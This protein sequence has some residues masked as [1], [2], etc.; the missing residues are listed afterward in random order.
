MGAGDKRDSF[1]RGAL[2][3]SV[4][5]LLTRVL[6]AVYRIPLYRLIG[7]EGMGLVQM[8]YPIY[9]TLLA[10]S[11]IGIPIAIS[12]M[13]AENL[14][15][16]NRSGAYRVFYL[17]L[18][19]LAA[20][21]FLFSLLLFFGAQHFA[22]TV[23][24]DPRSALALAAIAPA[25]FLVTVTSAFRGFFQGHLRMAPT[26]VSQVLEQLVRVGT[27]F[28]LAY[29]LMPRGLE[30]AAAGATF[31]A[32][33]GALVALGYLT[34]LFIIGRGAENPTRR[35]PWRVPEGNLQTVK[36]IVGLAV[37]ISLAG[38]VLPLILLVDM[39][40]VPRQLQAA[41]VGM[42][43]ATALYGQLSGG[44]M[45]LVNLPTVFTVA[46]ATS[47]V[48]AI[49]GASALGQ[50]EQIRSKV[51]TAL[52]LTTVI[53]LP[54]AAGLYILAREICAFLYAAPEVGV[55]LKSLAFLVLFLGFQ[56]TSAAVLQALG[57]T[58]IP[59]R[60]LVLGAILKLALTW[61]LTPVIG[62]QGAGLASVAGFLLAALMD[63][64]VIRRI[65]AVSLPVLGVLV[66]PLAATL[67][68]GL[69]VKASYSELL[70]VTGSNGLSVLG[71]VSIGMLGYGFLM[72]LMG[73]ITAR[74]VS[75]IPRV[76]PGLARM[77]GRL[78]TWREER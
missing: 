10:L 35:R 41:G 30:Y 47:L 11:T 22:K 55:P 69:A 17:S 4:A 15:V 26:A 39:L 34:V 16:K 32:V 78:P 6:G 27:M 36:R 5:H 18:A 52:R 61:Y 8:A 54:S 33:S 44:A 67:L 9:T 77:L 62:I 19:I 71:S 73:G 53:S 57:L 40:V 25:V 7:G 20:S 65:L 38:M 14:A 43:E 2:I 66:K 49:A 1:I 64:L 31:G 28:V 21:G 45:P 48:P 76:G 72:I 60:H 23:T 56:Q 68:M 37:P 51:T 13:V 70:V 58:I 24:Q 42:A 50:T 3:L 59:V 63:F 12:K 74:D 46:L 29:L 75:L